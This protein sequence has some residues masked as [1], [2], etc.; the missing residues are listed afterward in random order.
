MKRI[1]EGG[2]SL[3]QSHLRNL[4]GIVAVP[5]YLEIDLDLEGLIKV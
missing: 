1:G 5:R 4:E 2:L 3:G